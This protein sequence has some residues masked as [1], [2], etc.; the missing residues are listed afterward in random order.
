MVIVGLWWLYHSE[1]CYRGDLWP[2]VVRET[3]Q[4]DLLPQNQ[5]PVSVEKAWGESATQPILYQK[6]G[7]G[8]Y[9]WI[10]LCIT[11]IF[12]HNSNNFVSLRDA[13]FSSTSFDIKKKKKKDFLSISLIWFLISTFMWVLH[14]KAKVFLKNLYI[15]V[16]FFFLNWKIYL[17]ILVSRAL[18]LCQ[19]ING[20]SSSKEQWKITR[21]SVYIFNM[22]LWTGPSQID[23]LDF[24]VWSI[25]FSMLL[26]LDEFMFDLFSAWKK[27]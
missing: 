10:V 9:L 26:F 20:E 25:C 3:G 5:S 17:D 1:K 6:G 13:K 22:F 18:F 21:Y 4:H 14:V 11:C 12:S 16:V 8:V 19:R 23:T 27:M 24:V 7:R 15:H 2:L